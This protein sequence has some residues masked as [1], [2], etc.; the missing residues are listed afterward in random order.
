MKKTF[1]LLALSIAVLVTSC[2]K[3][4]IAAP[5]PVKKDVRF[6][7]G[8]TN[9]GQEVELNSEV[10]T[11]LGYKLNISLV[12][13]Y[14][15][16]IQLVKTNGDVVKVKD[17][18]LYDLSDA[19]S[20]LFTEQIP[21]GN[22][23]EVRFTI[24]LDQATNAS[25]PTSFDNNHPLSNYQ[26][27]YWSMLKYRFVVME[28]TANTASGAPGDAVSFAYHTGTDPAMRAYTSEYAFA[29]S[30]GSNTE[31]QFNLDLNTVLSGS[32]GELN[33]TTETSTHSSPSGMPL[34]LK[35]MDNIQAGF[36][37][38]AIHSMP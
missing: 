16:N 35:L 4:E 7:F 27:M 20:R 10:Q 37:V 17:V 26:G 12:R 34:T 30:T 13:L 14:L 25:D 18:M 19:D 5:A 3:E 29:I 23:T 32:G 9:N 31:L 33:P 36:Y 11:A 8:L 22:Y 28:G 6:S 1:Y 24:G 38:E 2:G 21:V 15:S